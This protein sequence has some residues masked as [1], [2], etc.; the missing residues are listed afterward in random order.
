MTI[1]DLSGFTIGVTAIDGASEQV[2][3]L[4]S[5]GAHVLHAPS[6]CHVPA[7]DQAEL[8]STIGEIGSDGLDLLV[9]TTDTGLRGLI[10]YADSFGLGEI[11]RHS[12]VSTH[13]VAANSRAAGETVASGLA[14]GWTGSGHDSEIV[15]RLGSQQTNDSNGSVL[16]V[17]VIVDGGR[18]TDLLVELQALGFQLVPIE[19]FE[20]AIPSELC[21]LNRL[22]EQLGTGAVD[23]VTFTGPAAVVNFFSAITAG[24]LGDKIHAA[25]E[26]GSVSAVALNSETSAELQKQGVRFAIQPTVDRL[27]SMVRALGNEMGRRGQSLALAGHTVDVRGRK[28]FLDGTE[29][30]SITG[31]ER[32]VLAAL[33][34]RNGAVVSKREL[35][36][37]V[38]GEL[39]DD[40]VVEVTVA[41]LRQRLG[42]AGSSI[43]T[44]VRRGYRLALGA[45]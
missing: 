34:Q 42:D 9:V 18:S 3:L 14:V 35:M 19:L 1:G 41:R 24:Q 44:V 45:P 26:N 36:R 39:G 10:N 23:A 21:S 12:L 32:S 33:A 25:F 6:V 40:H 17:G 31:R 27:G 30:S 13:I 4:E 28:M 5:R 37:E 2:G 16:R 43:E 11:L 7:A 29:L 20:S 15:R 8:R 22:I 38:W